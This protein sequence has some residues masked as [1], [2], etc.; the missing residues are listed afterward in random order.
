MKYQGLGQRRTIKDSV[1]MMKAI[2][3]MN[4]NKEK[5]ERKAPKNV[6]AEKKLEAKIICNL[7]L[8]GFLVYKTGGAGAY[9]FNQQ[10]NPD[11][12][13]DLIVCK[14]GRYWLLEIKVEK[15]RGWK[16]GGLTGKQPEFRDKCRE[17][18]IPYHIVYS[19]DD[20]MEIV[21]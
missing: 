20:V 4:N 10:H 5:K 12:M 15:K 17:L 8:N 14:G 9:D 21:K 2:E 16:N 3:D 7:K 6:M 19:L 18:G 13:A 11:G 1:K